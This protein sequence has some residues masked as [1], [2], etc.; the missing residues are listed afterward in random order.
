MRARGYSPKNIANN[1]GAVRCF[2]SW[3]ADE[4][5]LLP[6]DPLARFRPI[7]VPRRLP[8]VLAVSDVL[9]LLAAARTPRE[10][11][12]AELLYGSGIRKAELLGLDLADLDLGGLRAL[13]RGKGGRERYQPLSPQA[14]A[15]I[16]EWLPLRTV[17]LGRRRLD[18]L[19]VTREGRMGRQT[20][21]NLVHQ[22]ADRAGLDRRVYPHLLRHCF[23]THLLEGGAN[24]REVQELM[25]HANLST[26]GIYTHVSR[27]A[28][29]A[30]FRRAHP[31]GATPGEG[32]PGASPS[33]AGAAPCGG[34]GSGTGRNSAFA[35]G[36]EA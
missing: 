19:L 33:G 25:G 14:V 12:V 28:A 11:V 21:L 20:V 4:K 2:F 3:L 10:R 22:L 15:A 16:R 30:A 26:T 17:V 35:K 18:A 8:Q 13:I 34:D 36:S 24:L 1:V 31:R 5:G 23:A 7:K 32:A 6:R 9:K 27:G 29:D